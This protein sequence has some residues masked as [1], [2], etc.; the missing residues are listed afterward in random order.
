MNEK[1]RIVLA[2]D[3][4]LVTAGIRH[5][6]SQRPDFDVVAEARTPDALIEA[7]IALRP[8]VVITD[9]NMPGPT[10]FGDGIKLVSHIRNN[11]PDIRIVV[12]TMISSP[13]IASSL[14]G[15]GVSAVLLKSHDLSELTNSITSMI[16]EK[17]RPPGRRKAGQIDEGVDD[18][19]AQLT[20]KEMEVLRYLFSGMSVSEIALHV[21]R[22][23][24]TV[25]SHKMAAMRKLGAENDHEL[26]MFC[27]HNGLFTS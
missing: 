11:Y 5:M 21:N 4:P 12:L 2:D 19:I 7:I 13:V 6:L 26:I 20:P 16:L 22:S 25:S 10:R 17:R 9:Y 18:R 8:Q 1:I 14:Y 27:V 24:T 23:V 15:L 3:H